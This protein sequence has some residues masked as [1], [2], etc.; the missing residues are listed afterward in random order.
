[1]DLIVLQEMIFYY[2]LNLCKYELLI[3]IEKLNILFMIYDIIKL[4]FEI[5]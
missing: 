4:I 1:M 2:C 5:N 3:I